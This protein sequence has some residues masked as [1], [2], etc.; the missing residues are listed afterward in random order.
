MAGNGAIDLAGQPA[1]A[2][3]GAFRR[4]G[5]PMALVAAVLAV[6]LLMASTA[7][8]QLT[9][10][11]SGTGYWV[12]TTGTTGRWLQSGTAV[13]DTGNWVAGSNAT[14][15]DAGTYTFGRLVATGSATLG[16]ITTGTGVFISFSDTGAGNVMSFGNAVKTF[17]FG[18]GSV[19]NFGGI[20]SAGANGIIKTG[21]GTMMFQGNHT[22]GFTLGTSGSVG[23]TFIARANAALS[24]GAITINSG[25]IGGI[26]N[27][28]SPVRS[29]GITVGGDFTMGATGTI[30][31]STLEGFN[32]TFNNAGNTVNLTGGTR[33]ITLNTSG[34]VSFGQA[35]SNGSLTLN[36]LA[37]G[38]A[39]AFALSGSNS[40]S[41]LTLDSVKLNVTSS[42]FALGSGTV[43]LQG[44][45]ATTLN[46]NDGRTFANAF[47]IADSAGFKTIATIANS[48][49]SGTITN[50]DSTGGLVLGGTATRTLTV[51]LI[52]G[53]G[54][55]GVTFGSSALT[56]TVTLTGSS[57]YTGDTRID[58][59]TLGIT[60][61][62]AVPAGGNLVFQGSGT[63]TFDV[64]GTTQTVAGLNDSVLAGAIRS[65][66]A[67]GKLIVGDSNDSTFRGVMST[68]NL[69]LEKVGTG[70][71]T[72]TGANTYSGA[73]TLTAGTL[74]LGS[75][76]AIGSS[77]TIS[78][79]GGTLQSSASN[80]ADYSAR[81]SNA[82]N[83]Q[84]KIDTNGQNVTLASN[85]TSS[86]GS[87]TKLGA[88]TLTL[89]G[90]NSYSGGTTVSAG[91]LV[92]TT[93]S[94]QG[95][96]TNN[97]AVTFDQPTDGT[98]SGV[99]SGSGSLT[100]AGSG[101]LTLSG[102]NSYSGGTTVSAGSLIAGN[103]SAFGAGA[104]TVEAGAT[105]DIAGL[106]VPNALVNNG[107]TILGVD[108]PTGSLSGDNTFSETTIAA[109]TVTS[110]TTTFAGPVSGSVAVDSG[111]AVVF[112]SD[113]N[114]S[115][116]VGGNVSFSAPASE[117]S[118]V[119]VT[120][121]GTATFE[122]GASY[123]GAAITNNGNIVVDVASTFALG[124]VSGAGSLAVVGTGSVELN[125][126]NDYSGTTNVTNGTLI[127][128]GTVSA[129]HVTIGS[130]GTLGG[131]GTLGAPL[132]VQSGGVLSPGNS[133]GIL[134]AAELDLRA[135]STTLMQVIGSGL[136]AG[137]AGTDY[138]QVQ[139]TTASSLTY[140]GEL[141][142]SF[143]NSPLF[144]NGTLFSLFQFTGTARGGFTSVRTEGTGS[145]S[146]LTLQYN[147]NGNW[148]TNPNTAA[149]QYLVLSPA[150]GQLAIV[151]EPSTWVM[152]AIGA[153]LVALK[154]RRR[155]RADASLAA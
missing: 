20:T 123:A 84:V 73:T 79:G 120:V 46:F 95:S 89:S 140:G 18:A 86:G 60:G 133:P 122:N 136:A 121:G 36:R 68:A 48:T 148:Y 147:S 69:A 138:D 142:L 96:I 8:A 2:K 112:T 55:R 139:I 21:A 155:K 130:G 70:K 40:F 17:D 74:A 99:M 88:G 124:G 58:S 50:N 4:L 31:G 137:T 42:N 116:T 78:F 72:L 53:T 45:N 128:N 1:V 132:A 145:Y 146:G 113:V 80:T 35:V 125:G 3:A 98:Y 32:V 19:V 27:F 49:I 29:G 144:D 5:R 22:G 67:N 105:L 14:F 111:A 127:V 81:F 143:I 34:V 108:T 102:A 30:G 43:T 52:S 12:V 90:S 71:L 51:G 119:N 104:V 24:A 6:A 9:T 149:G 141:V 28:T 47:T 110:G 11:T 93:S 87:F 37:T 23:G 152:A 94:L 129:S 92:G 82:A 59:S 61:T 100:K 131:S 63:A 54:S 103:A 101:T 76:N 154:A 115:V 109:V 83:Q 7:S 77:G 66:A 41:A 151:P 75:A 15:A 135:G 117:S 65:T 13:N 114:A 107:G 106:L 10:T 85:L 16:N 134:A 97:A 44:T 91:S 126:V 38:S 118:A 26:Q 57:N 39:G 56:G 150:S 25:T 153:G 62:G 64:N 33:A